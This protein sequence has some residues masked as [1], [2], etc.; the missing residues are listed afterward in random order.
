MF[1]SH[2][3]LE[4]RLNIQPNGSTRQPIRPQHDFLGVDPLSS[5]RESEQYGGTLEMRLLREDHEVSNSGYGSAR[6][7]SR[8]V[9]LPTRHVYTGGVGYVSCMTVH[10]CTDDSVECAISLSPRT[11]RIGN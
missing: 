2:A 11:S 4:Q 9:S 3:H 5:M 7:V 8:L 6:R 1:P 10:A